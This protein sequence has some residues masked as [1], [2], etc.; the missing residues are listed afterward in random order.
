M[1]YH[2]RA[3]E[4]VTYGKVGPAPESEIDPFFLHPY[5]WLGAHC[6]YFPQ[7]W[8]ARGSSGN[9]GFRYTCRNWG[10]A[11]KRGGS[12]GRKRPTNI[13]FG[14]DLVKGFPVDMDMWHIIL[15]TLGNAG[16]FRSLVRSNAL[17]K[18][19]LD[20]FVEWAREN[21][22]LED[23]DML[24]DWS[25]HPYLERFR[26]RWLFVETDQVVLPALN[27]KSAKRIICRDE[28]QRRALRKMGFIEDRIVIRNT[29]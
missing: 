27:L 2:S 12:Y 26:N 19:S 29:K 1:Y 14:F 7:V 10:A 28:R 24:K 21:C 9:T 5:R 3:I 11:K 13:L 8:L 23:N 16:P 20:D 22:G 18:A 15:N 6:G 4:Y 17:L 25:L